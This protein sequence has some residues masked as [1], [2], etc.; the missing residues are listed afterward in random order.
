MLIFRGVFVIFEKNGKW[1]APSYQLAG[2]RSDLPLESLSASCRKW[3]QI[4][5]SADFPEARK[6]GGNASL[7][8][9]VIAA[10]PASSSCSCCGCSCSCC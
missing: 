3:P 2:R 9:V 8:L 10:V 1:L 4:P 6:A 5:K 7:L